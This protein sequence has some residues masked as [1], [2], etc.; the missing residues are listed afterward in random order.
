MGAKAVVG[1]LLQWELRSLLGHFVIAVGIEVIIGSQ[2]SYLKS[3]HSDDLGKHCCPCYFYW[4]RVI[5][6]HGSFEPWLSV[7]PPADITVYNVTWTTI[8]EFQ[9]TLKS[10]PFQSCDILKFES[11]VYGVMD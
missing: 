6:V 11:Y 10:T 9:C 7:K 3:H 2:S 4:V 8:M 1:T 5:Y